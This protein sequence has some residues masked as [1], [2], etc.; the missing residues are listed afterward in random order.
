[1][2]KNL[3]LK[4]AITILLVSSVFLT[5]CS[6]EELN[7][8]PWKSIETAIDNIE[9]KS[10]ELLKETGDYLQK[11]VKDLMERIDGTVDEEIETPTSSNGTNNYLETYRSKALEV[12]FNEIPRNYDFGFDSEAETYLLKRLNDYRTENGLNP[13]EFRQDLSESARYKSLA[14][15]QYDYF[16]HD[17]PNLG[18]KPFDYLMWDVLDLSYTSVGENLAFIGNSSPDMKIEAEELFQGWKNSPSHNEQMLNPYHKYIGI[19]VIRSDKT[20]PYFDG[21]KAI[22]GTQHFGG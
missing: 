12:A 14:M 15:L 3:K 20:G 7:N 1:M 5:G 2:K 10:N 17:N 21:Y 6:N 8:D 11:A 4:K 13:L 18:G 9:K 19:G 16:S 22:I